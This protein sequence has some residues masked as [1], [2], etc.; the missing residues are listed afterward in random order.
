[1]KAKAKRRLAVVLG[2]IA[3]VVVVL[4]AFG[5]GTSAKTTTVAQAAKGS[6]G[7]GKIQVTGTVADNSY[8]IDG[9]VLTFSMY[10]PDGDQS[11]QLKVRYDKGVS[12]T[13]GNGVQAICTGRMGSDGVLECSELVTKCP[14][15]YESATD[16]LSVA[17]LVA[18]GSDV[19]DKP[20]KV[21][22]NVQAGTLASAGNDVRLVIEDADG[23]SSMPVAYDGAL[24]DDVTDGTA[25][26]LTGSLDSAGTFQATDVALPNK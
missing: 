21:T 10:D 16:A 7:S 8:T 2:I 17:R 13:F 25:L 5:A 23:T 6:A 1:M 19:V 11:V 22:G 4:A 26:V 14:S 24:P 9:D 20:V 18:Y 3:V 15:K 12:A